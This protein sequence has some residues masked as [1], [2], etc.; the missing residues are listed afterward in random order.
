MSIDEAPKAQA[1]IYAI[2][3]VASGTAYV[4]QTFNARRRRCEHFSRLR[5]QD[6]KNAH[7]QA[8]FNKYGSDSFQ[9]YVLEYCPIESLTAREAHWMAVLAVDG[10]YNTNPAGGSPLGIKRSEETRKKIAAASKGRMRGFQHSPESRARM[11]LWQRGRKRPPFSEE[12][13][14]KIA[15]ANLGRKHPPRSQ[16]FRERVRLQRLGTTM[17]Q[18]VRD[19]ISASG[20]GKK[21]SAATRQKISAAKKAFWAVRR[22]E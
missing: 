15:A 21:R 1:A 14:R 8:A 20:R 16:E 2:R 6:H 17:P 11:S 13:R 22:G 18:A 7:L 3:H 4:G 19:K 10:L 5:N 9:F 12:W